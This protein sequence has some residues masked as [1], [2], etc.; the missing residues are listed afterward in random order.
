ML[1]KQINNHLYDFTTWPV[2]NRNSIPVHR[3][4][5]L[6][7]EVKETFLSAHHRPDP[8]SSPVGSCR[9]RTPGVAPSPASPTRADRLCF[10]PLHSLYFPAVRGRCPRLSWPQNVDPVVPRLTAPGGSNGTRST[11]PHTPRDP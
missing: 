5:T 8:I 1:K 11:Q 2:G 9:G 3:L 4:H 6:A 10:E 7:P